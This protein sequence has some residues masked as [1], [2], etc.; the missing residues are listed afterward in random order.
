MTTMANTAT[1]LADDPLP[2]CRRSLEPDKSVTS[3][4]L[5]IDR[6]GPIELVSEFGS[7]SLPLQGRAWWGLGPVSRLL[8]LGGGAGPGGGR[9]SPGLVPGDAVE[10]VAEIGGIGRTRLEWRVRQVGERILG[11]A[12]GLEG[13]ARQ[14][15]PGRIAQVKGADRDFRVAIKRRRDRIA[16]RVV[17]IRR[18]IGDLVAVERRRHVRLVG[19][20][21]DDDAADGV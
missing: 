13:D 2:A 8:R 3:L 19:Q 6:L 17:R 16:D 18:G 10:R 4:D 14:V 15:G 12:A 7:V 5:T 11:L 9:E 20:R 1:T 21:L